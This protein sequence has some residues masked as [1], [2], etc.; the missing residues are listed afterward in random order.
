MFP[1]LSDTL[2]T[3][4]D[5]LNIIAIAIKFP[6][7]VGGIVR[8]VIGFPKLDALCTRAQVTNVAVGLRLLFMTTLQGLPPVQAPLHPE[9]DQLTAALA[10]SVTE[11]PLG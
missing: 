8:L 6:V 5:P 1:A 7:P 9:N 2:A 3:D 11:L 4:V 10:V